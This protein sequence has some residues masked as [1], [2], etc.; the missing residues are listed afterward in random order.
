MFQKNLYYFVILIDSR[1][2]DFNSMRR[3]NPKLNARCL[4]AFPFA[5]NNISIHEKKNK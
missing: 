3:N 1:L 5:V 2:N 4:N